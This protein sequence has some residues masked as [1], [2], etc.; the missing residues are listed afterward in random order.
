[1][2]EYG[3]IVCV[4][5]GAHKNRIGI[6]DGDEGKRAI[7]LFGDILLSDA[8]YIIPFT[9][10]R[11][12]TMADLFQ[13]REEI[14]QNISILKIRDRV[15]KN[16]DCK[17]Y[18]MLMELNLIDNAINSRDI[19]ARYGACAHAAKKIFISH[20]KKDKWLANR[21][22][23]D[24]KQLGHDPWVDDFKINVGDSIPKSIQ[25]GIDD[26][27]FMVVL[28]SENSIQSGWVEQEWMTKYW[29]ERQGQRTIIL[30]A[31]TEPCNIPA[32]LKTKK[33]A[34]FV[35]SYQM[36]LGEIIEA[37]MKQ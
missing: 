4:T 8:Y 30:P 9:S 33:Y 7:I 32:L 14:F 36:G 11:L 26:S 18:F 21:L 12:A 22:M 28:L 19:H 17:K 20:S 31:L 34:N 16:S 1:M 3:D 2:I 10:L 23:S 13:R 27:D 37:I 25:S 6:Y 5:K 15:V 35:E 24:L 29:D